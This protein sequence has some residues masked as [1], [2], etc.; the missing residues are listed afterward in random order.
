[1]SLRGRLLLAAAAMVTIA[2]VVADFATY[3]QLRSNLYNQVDARLESFRNTAESSSATVGLVGGFVEIRDAADRVVK[4][5]PDGP[6]VPAL[7]THIS[8][9]TTSGTSHRAEAWFNTDSAEPGHRTYRV[10]ATQYPDGSQ[11]I[12]ALPL[13]QV[14]ITL[15]H[16]ARVDFSVT[17]LALFGVVALGWWLIR[18]SLRPLADMERTAAAIAD[19]DLARRVPGDTEVTEVGRLARTLNVM[20]SRIQDAFAARDATER[21]LRQSEE[22]L[23]RF[24]ADASHELRTP[25]AAVSAYAEL[26]ERGA[27][28]RPE[29]LARVLSGIRSETVRMGELV[30]DLLLLARLDEGR[31]LEQQPVELVGLAAEAV[32]A[33]AAVGPRWPVRL[34]ANHTVE[35]TG[36]SARLRQVVDNLLANVRAH[37]PPGTAA[38]VR[39]GAR[40]GSG[41]IEV[42]DNGPGL[43]TESGGQ[44]FERFYRADPSRSRQNG[45]AGLGLAIVAAIVAAHGGT[46]AT[47]AT[48]GG[49]ATFTVWLPTDPEA[50]APPGSGAAAGAGALTAPATNDGTAVA[51]D[52]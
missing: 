14:T 22:R 37:T 26:F 18:L 30:E 38:T 27:A 2:L 7:P 15:H 33:A 44:V 47:T 23:R 8:D 17:V 25:V 3:S 5:I 13:D 12:T 16:Q 6:D 41:V 10:L 51:S 46:V 28:S 43:P 31:P 11:L 24:V 40:A 49:G 50:A 34:E 19:G 36:D 48:P 1:M 4:P 9:F 21:Q 39:V 45:G 42:S 20:L 29:D 32:S 52:Q 35:V